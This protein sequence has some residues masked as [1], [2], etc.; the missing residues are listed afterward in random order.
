MP[1]TIKRPPSPVQRLE[2]TCSVDP[3]IDKLEVA[4]EDGK[5]WFRSAR[6]SGGTT[7]DYVSVTMNRDE[8]AAFA[9]AF[10]AFIEQES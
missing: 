3:D 6:K 4:F 1:L 9:N 2:V 10:M 8:A 5:F 7:T